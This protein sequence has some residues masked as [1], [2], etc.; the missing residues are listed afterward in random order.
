MSRSALRNP[1]ALAVL[2]TLVEGPM[3]PYRITR[4]LRERGKEHSIRLNWGSLYSVIA[5]LER[6]G[7]IEATHSERE[8][9]RP[10]RTVYAITEAGR[11][12]AMG[13]LRYLIEVPAKEYPDFEAGLSLVM[14]LPPEETLDLLRSRLARL[15]ERLAETRGMTEYPL[16]EVFLLESRYELAMLEAERAFVAELVGRLEAGDVGGQ[17]MWTEMHRRL[18]AG[19]SAEDLVAQ[20]DEYLLKEE[21]TATDATQRPGTG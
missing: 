8:G 5:S 1:L 18:A 12:E 9:A 10:T 21:S 7:F 2:A 11:A 13:W 15:D 16:P 6:H 4:V 20:L 19:E 14:L 3:H 17:G